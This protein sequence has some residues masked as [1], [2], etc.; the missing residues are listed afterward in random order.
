MYDDA[1][2]TVN[3]KCNIIKQH[4]P[5]H[6]VISNGKFVSKSTDLGTDIVI[7]L[8]DGPISVCLVQKK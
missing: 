2:H 4:V 6:A 3:N 7:M 5:S 1:L 8:D